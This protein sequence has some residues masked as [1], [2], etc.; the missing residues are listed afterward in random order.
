MASLEDVMVLLVI[1]V[2]EYLLYPHLAK[3]LH[4]NFPPLHKV[5]DKVV[6]IIM[7]LIDIL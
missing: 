1:V 6:I 5:S 4:Y 3:K 2:T 7:S